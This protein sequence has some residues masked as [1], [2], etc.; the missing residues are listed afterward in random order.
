[1]EKLNAYIEQVKKELVHAIDIKA[2][3]E[4]KINRLETILSNASFYYEKEA[5][6]KTT[7]FRKANGEK[8]SLTNKTSFQ[9]RT[10]SNVPE[11]EPEI[12][13]AGGPA[14]VEKKEEKSK[15]SLF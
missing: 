8:I 11:K 9:K 15:W 10:V 12:S 6:K 5:K 14:G 3:M 1:M 7:R 2:S 4:R 13:V